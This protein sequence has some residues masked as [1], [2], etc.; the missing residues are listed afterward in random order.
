MA[1][2]PQVSVSDESGHER[3]EVRVDGEKA[4]L[5]TYRRLPDRTVLLHTE[6]DERFEG[7]GLGSQLIRAALDGE[8]ERGQH[9]EPRCPFVARFITRHPEYGD[10]VPDAYRPLLES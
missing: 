3:Y 4:G 10:L 5:V 6:I 8:R 2:D 7:R 1:D 9:V